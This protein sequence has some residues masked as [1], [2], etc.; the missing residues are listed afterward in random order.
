MFSH[1]LNLVVAGNIVNDTIAPSEPEHKMFPE[2]VSQDEKLIDT[3]ESLV[4]V[5]SDLSKGLANGLTALSGA[6]KTCGF[7]NDS[8]SDSDREEPKKLPLPDNLRPPIW[9]EVCNS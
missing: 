4:A 7:S 8:D 2:H 9:A 6:W 1:P 3:E 5:D